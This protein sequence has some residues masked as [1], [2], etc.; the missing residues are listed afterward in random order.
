MHDTRKRQQS[1]TQHLFW[2]SKEMDL[3]RSESYG[4][5]VPYD[6]PLGHILYVP[7]ANAMPNDMPDLNAVEDVPVVFIAPNSSIRQ[8]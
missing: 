8:S 6:D 7:R 3:K 2:L 1:F 5:S 4:T